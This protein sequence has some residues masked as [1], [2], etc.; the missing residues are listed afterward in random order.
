MI[1]SIY[2]QR[3]KPCV[4]PC[5]TLNWP[6]GPLLSDGYA[7]LR[8]T[9]PKTTSKRYFI[10]RHERGQSRRGFFLDAIQDSVDITNSGIGNRHMFTE[11][12]TVSLKSRKHECYQNNSMEAVNC[13]NDFMAEE[14]DCQLPWD[15]NPDLK[16][17][18]CKT[19][20]QFAAFWNLSLKMTSLES[21]VKLKRKGCFVPNC[22][23][24]S[25]KLLK[26]ELKK[27]DQE[28]DLNQFA[29]N[30]YVSSHAKVLKREEVKLADFSTFLADFGSYIGL[31][32]GAS[33]LSVIDYIFEMFGKLRSMQWCQKI[34]DS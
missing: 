2:V 29:F 27:F 10:E 14:L 13:F 33:F 15:L 9:I 7:I 1:F 20:L 24:R 17:D 6:F 23:Q 28:E 21:K 34:R 16:M 30:A 22:I 3:Y 26:L 4:V 8:I 5:F 12:L 25:W 31:F 32:L 19:E 18:R 11:T